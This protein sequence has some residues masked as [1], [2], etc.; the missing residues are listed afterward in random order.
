MPIIASARLFPE[1]GLG[2]KSRGD[3]GN[4][5]GHPVPERMVCPKSEFCLLLRLKH[6]YSVSE[7]RNMSLADNSQNEQVFGPVI[8]FQGE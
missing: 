5:V 8:S 3:P 6:A 2:G 7:L 4:G 1:M